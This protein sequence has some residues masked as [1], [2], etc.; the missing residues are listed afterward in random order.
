MNDIIY[1]VWLALKNGAGHSDAVKLLK[2]FPGGA[3]EIYEAPYERLAAVKECSE[4]FIKR[5]TD[6][7]LSQ[8][9]RILEFCFMNGIRVVTCASSHYPRRLQELYN[10]PIV[11][12]I[13]GMIE[14]IDDRFCVSIVGTR[15]MSN[16]G[17]HITF[18][19]ARQLIGYGALIISGAAYGIDSTANRTAVF[20]EEPTVAVLGSGV[21]VPY[22]AQNKSMLDLIGTHGMVISEFEPNTPPYGRNFPIR[23]RIM[24]GLADAVVVVEADEKSGALITAR[25]AADQGRSV[26]AVPGNIGATNSIGPL[27][28]IRDG[29]KIVT[30]VEDIIEDF[31]DRFKL[32]KLD[33]IVKSDKYLRYEYN[34]SIPVQAENVPMQSEEQNLPAVLNVPMTKRSTDAPAFPDIPTPTDYRGKSGADVRS[35]PL[36]AP[37]AYDTADDIPYDMA[38]RT[39]GSTAVS[40]NDRRLPSRN[41][42]ERHIR[43]ESKGSKEIQSKAAPSSEI[44]SERDWIYSKLGETQIKVLEAFPKDTP[45]SPDKLAECGIDIGD[46]LSSLTVLELYSAVEALPG[47]L[48]KRKI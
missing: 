16:Y 38:D 39:D 10:K 33:R 7:D 3:R 37:D 25:H 8:P 32:K 24:S 46:V 27:R 12:Y 9:E 5:L 36:S 18:T 6:H 47:G 41:G 45:M 4:L 14:D 26:Y 1:W 11:L 23:N 48:Y 22:P 20:F 40:K 17:K 43:K 15:K 2:H 19:L 42:S 35:I 31:T 34:H 44:A 13:R 29:A 21:N 30:C 28:M